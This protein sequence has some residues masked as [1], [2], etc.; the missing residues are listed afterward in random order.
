MVWYGMCILT[1]NEFTNG[2]WFE[3]LLAFICLGF[4]PEFALPVKLVLELR[5][6]TSVN[7]V[8]DSHFDRS[9]SKNLQTMFLKSKVFSAGIRN[10]RVYNYVKKGERNQTRLPYTV[11]IGLEAI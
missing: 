8:L 7:H 11:E 2:G 4:P 1:H 3:C 6:Q 10:A 9:T 5:R